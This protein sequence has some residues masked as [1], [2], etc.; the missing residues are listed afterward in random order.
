[1]AIF[2]LLLLVI[3]V[4]AVAVLVTYMLGIWSSLERQETADPAPPVRHDAET[5][6][7]GD[8]TPT[9]R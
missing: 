7:R 4:M 1:M 8:P 2:F 6:T 9:N 5:V 3:V